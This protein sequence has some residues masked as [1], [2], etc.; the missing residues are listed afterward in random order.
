MSF[1]AKRLTVAYISAEARIPLFEEKLAPSQA[2]SRKERYASRLPGGDRPPFSRLSRIQ[3]HAM[4]DPAGDTTHLLHL[5]HAG[6]AQAR[7]ALLTY[8]CQRLLCLTRRMLRDY[9]GLHRWEETDD[10]FQSAML[11]LHRALADVPLESPR[12]FWRLAALQ[13]RRALLDLARHHLGPGGPGA[14][15]HTDAQGRAADDHEDCLQ[16]HADDRGSGPDSLQEWTAFHEQ[17]GTLPEDEREVFGL[18]WYQGLTQAGAAA[19][20]GVSLRTVKRRWQ[21]ARLLLAEALPGRD[22]G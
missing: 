10:V 22:E 5:L 4:T 15:H 17:V 11:R 12:H 19:V 1:L 6:D 13:I 2:G 7:D 14:R 18:L 20:L 8:A 16:T 21:S 9:P 3:A